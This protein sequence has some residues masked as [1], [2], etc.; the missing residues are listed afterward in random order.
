MIEIEDALMGGSERKL[1]LEAQSIIDPIL[2]DKVRWQKETYLVAQAYG[3]KQLRKQLNQI[4]HRLFSEPQ[5]LQFKTRIL[6]Y[7]KTK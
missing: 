6:S 3:R 4:H 5:H 7:F 1:L 2:A